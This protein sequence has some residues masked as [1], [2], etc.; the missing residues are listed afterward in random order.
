MFL[1]PAGT[2][3]DIVKKLSDALVVAS[4]TPDVIKRIRDAGAA[5]LGGSS[6]DLARHIDAEYVKWKKVVEAARL[7][8]Q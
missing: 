2:P 7:E 4:K 6:T 8:P 3:A 1:A 5:E